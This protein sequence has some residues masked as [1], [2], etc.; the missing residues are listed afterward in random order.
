MR[1]VALKEKITN[2][3]EL[4]KLIF[5]LFFGDLAGTLSILRYD[6]FN[7]LSFT[8]IVSLLWLVLALFIVWNKMEYYL[9]LLEEDKDENYSN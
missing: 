5:A 1:E 6:G 8:G 2:L 9:N 3:R 7:L 4:F